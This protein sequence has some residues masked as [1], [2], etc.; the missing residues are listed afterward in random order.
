MSQQEFEINEYEFK[1]FSVTANDSDKV[2]DYSFKDLGEIVPKLAKRNSDQVKFERNAAEK[3]NFIISPIVKEHRGLVEQEQE[4]RDRKILAEVTRRVELVKEK[5]F[6]EGFDEGVNAGRLDVFNQ[7]KV[8]SEEKL[9]NLAL[10]VDEVL[11]A[12]EEI[13]LAQK[14]DIYKL[15]RNLTKWVILRELK[16]DGDYVNRLLEK[17]IIETQTN[18]NLLIQVNQNQ[19]SNMP[20][21]LETVEKSL[22]KLENVRVEIDDEVSDNGIVVDSD[23]GIIKGTLEQQFES[24][25]KLFETVGID[26]KDEEASSSSEE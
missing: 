12:K 9:S 16:D 17:L 5:A 14:D 13:L 20:E 3:S 1:S 23:N 2:K 21:V 19:F 4:E 24:L 25:D 18:S 22:G 26:S 8:E 10:M 6:K 15:I 11:K 7:T